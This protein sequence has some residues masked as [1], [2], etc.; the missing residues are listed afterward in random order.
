MYIN[1]S[2]GHATEHDEVV[3]INKS[4][5]IRQAFACHLLLVQK[6]KALYRNAFFQPTRLQG[7][8]NKIKKPPSE[9][10][11]TRKGNSPVDCWQP[12]C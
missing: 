8:E 5:L 3:Y 1:K 2:I 10:G 6:E 11:A 12:K 7:I 4:N 9:E